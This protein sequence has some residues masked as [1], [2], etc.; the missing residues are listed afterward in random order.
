MNQWSVYLERNRNKK[1]PKG[2]Y[3]MKSLNVKYVYSNLMYTVYYII[4]IKYVNY[5]DLCTYMY[6]VNLYY[7]RHLWV[8]KVALSS[9]N[10]HYTVAPNPNLFWLFV[11]N[12]YLLTTSE[13]YSTV[14]EEWNSDRYITLGV[15]YQW[16][17]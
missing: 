9:I 11:T 4:I 15:S 13:M 5:I 17:K 1:I 2:K 3:N 7:P 10:M 8:K 16:L 6:T 14:D 12:K